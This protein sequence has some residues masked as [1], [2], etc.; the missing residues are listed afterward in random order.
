MSKQVLNTNTTISRSNGDIGILTFYEQGD[1][2]LSVFLCE[3]VRNT[4]GVSF[5]EGELGVT[6]NNFNSVRFFVNSKGELIANGSE[7]SNFSIDGS[8]NLIYEKT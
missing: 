1:K 3:E 7:A 4:D 5:L 6:Y 2:L 8:G